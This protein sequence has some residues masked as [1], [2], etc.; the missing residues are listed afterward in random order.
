MATEQIKKSDWQGYFSKLTN[1]IEGL[2]IAVEIDSPEFGA[3]NQSAKLQVQGLTYD[4]KSDLFEISSNDI[5][6]IV[7]KPKDIYVE[8][9]EGIVHSIKVEDGENNA[10]ILTFLPPLSLPLVR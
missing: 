9:T 6:H 1:H 10:H 2:N 8:S 3:Q 5:E 7:N 4:P